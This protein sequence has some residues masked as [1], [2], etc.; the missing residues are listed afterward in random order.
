VRETSEFFNLARTGKSRYAIRWTNHIDSA[1]YLRKTARV[2]VRVAAPVFCTGLRS[3]SRRDHRYCCRDR[4]S[5]G[6]V[7]RVPSR[8]A[9]HRNSV[10]HY[11]SDTTQRVLENEIGTF[12]RCNPESQMLR[13]GV[14]HSASIKERQSIER[15]PERCA[16]IAI[17][18]STTLERVNEEMFVATVPGPTHRRI[19]VASYAR[20]ANA[21]R[22]RWALQRLPETGP[23]AAAACSSARHR[24]RSQ[25]VCL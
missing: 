18:R 8:A 14:A 12:R 17:A 20:G 6:A 1:A 11:G 13:P 16:T 9:A 5:L 25:P 2:L 22:R 15:S 19:F 7:K 4:Y 10:L 21:A 23:K 3:C 24:H